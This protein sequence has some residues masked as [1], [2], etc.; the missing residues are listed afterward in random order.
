MSESKLNIQFALVK[1]T[2]EQFAILGELPKNDEK[3]KMNF[4]HRFA[5]N[6]DK[7]LI[8][9]FVK[10]DFIYDNKVFLTLE[11]ACHFK[12][13]NK[14]W[15]KLT[16]GESNHLNLPKGFATHL[17]VLAV[18]TARGILHAKT[19]QTDFNRYFIPLLNISG[20]IKRDVIFKLLKP[21]KQNI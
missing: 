1:I 12:I 15:Q 3:V 10:F 9:V 21:E 19:S 4:H 14:D 17:L 20:M 8:G 2:T 6:S 7:H 18:G 11:S 13:D 16:D 5:F